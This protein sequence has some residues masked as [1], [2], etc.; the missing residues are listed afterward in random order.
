MG[1]PI[2]PMGSS[3]A[4]ESSAVAMPSSPIQTIGPSPAVRIPQEG[5]A[6]PRPPA[7][8]IVRCGSSYGTTPCT[9]GRTVENPAAT[10]FDTTRSSRLA[11][12]M[13]EGRIPGESTNITSFSTTTTV[14]GATTMCQSS[15]GSEC[16]DFASRLIGIDSDA[17]RPH[18]LPYQDWLSAQR[19]QVRDLQAAVHC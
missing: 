16:T 11:V 13:E 4:F 7:T 18:P 2:L 12:L 15:T 17:R 9:N 14:N 1:K 8:T 19:Q 5:Q 3:D 10:G 6:L